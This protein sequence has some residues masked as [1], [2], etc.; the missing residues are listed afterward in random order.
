MSITAGKYIGRAT[1]EVVL[2]VS[3][4]KGTPYIEFLF[5]VGGDAN[6]TPS[7]VR[8]TGYFTEK[9]QERTIEALQHCGWDGDNLSEFADHDL[10]GLDRN[11]VEL[12]IEVEEWTANN[13]DTRETPKVKWINRLG[14]GGGVKV[15]NA[16]DA[17]SSQ[18]FGDKMRGLVL[19]TKAKHGSTSSGP[20]AGSSKPKSF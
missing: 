3:K 10:H 16:M 8:W 12:V 18:A 20:A 19:A 15:E 9:A 13:G 6:E 7:T 2:G 17:S 5:D 1:G 4:N 14:G 11:E